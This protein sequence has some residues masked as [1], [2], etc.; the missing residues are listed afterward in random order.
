MNKTFKELGEEIGALVDEKNTAYGDS[1]A[2]SGEFLKLLFPDGIR[3]DQYKDALCLVRIFD[4][5]MR[6]ATDKNAFGE[7]P[8]GDISGYGLLGLKLCDKDAVQTSSCPEKIDSGASDEA[9]LEKK[10]TK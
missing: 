2:K 10:G 1:F 6:I 3:P 9:G 4:K 7:S 5:Q 8:Y